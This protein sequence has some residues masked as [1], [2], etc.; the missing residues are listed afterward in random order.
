MAGTNPQTANDVNVVAGG[1]GR[2]FVLLQ[3]Q[4]ARNQAW[5]AAHDLKIAPYNMT[6]ADEADVKSAISGLNTALAAIDRTF[7]DRLTGLF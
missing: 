3:Q 5:L 1:L 2:Q 6:S 7:I 4:V